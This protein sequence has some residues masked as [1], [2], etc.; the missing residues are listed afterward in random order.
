MTKYWGGKGR[1]GKDIAVAILKEV[2]DRAVK[3]AEPFTHYWEPFVGMGGVM[4]HMVE[5]LRGYN[6][7]IEIM[8]SDLN[9]GVINFWNHIKDK[10]LDPDGV[11]GGETPLGCYTLLKA[12]KHEHTA[13]HTF[14]GHACGFHGIYFSGKHT[15][16]E[17]V[18]KLIKTANRSVQKV[19][20]IM[21]Q[22]DRYIK[23]DFIDMVDAIHQM[24]DGN[25]PT[26]WIIY[27]DPPYGGDPSTAPW[28]IKGDDS[29]I[30]NTQLFWE[31]A[32]I[33]SQPIYNNIV[34]ISEANCPE[35][36]QSRWISIWNRG[37]KNKGLNPVAGKRIQREEHLWALREAEP[38]NPGDEDEEDPP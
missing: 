30:F 26:N 3:G 25:P 2:K 33:W 28:G 14:I 4:R 31:F 15:S 29:S 13:E 23:A 21:K 20:P 11:I 18:Q 5:P 35:T 7:D 24:N 22:V 38:V 34:L 27:L 9:P 8:A 37:W 36:F 6:P 1:I 16:D 32:T 19:A 17:E 10:G 12:T